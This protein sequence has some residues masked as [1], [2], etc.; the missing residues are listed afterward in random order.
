LL[1]AQK[2]ASAQQK[3][4]AEDSGEEDGETDPNFTEL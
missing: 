1:A 2:S 4:T 3:V